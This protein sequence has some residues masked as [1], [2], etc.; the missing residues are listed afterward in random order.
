MKRMFLID[1]FSTFIGVC[2]LAT[3]SLLRYMF[4]LFIVIT[5]CGFAFGAR[6]GV[7][8]VHKPVGRIV[9]VLLSAFAWIGIASAAIIWWVNRYGE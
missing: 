7:L 6:A 2:A 4:G 1:A 3:S 9:I 5:V 8:A